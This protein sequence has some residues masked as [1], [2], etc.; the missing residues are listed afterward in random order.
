M[1]STKFFLLSVVLLLMVSVSTLQAQTSIF[2]DFVCDSPDCEGVAPLEG[3]WELSDTGL[4]PNERRGGNPGEIINFYLEIGPQSFNLSDFSEPFSGKIILICNDGSSLEGLY[5]GNPSNTIE[6]SKVENFVKT[7]TVTMH[8]QLT[9][10]TRSISC[11][12]AGCGDIN[13][14]V[15]PGRW[16]RRGAEPPDSDGDGVPDDQD[17]CQGGDDNV[18]TDGDLVP[19]F[20]D[21]CPNDIENDADGDGVC[22]DVDSCPGGNDNENADGDALPDF[23]DVCPIDPDNDADGDG[24]CGD[25]DNCPIIANDNQNDIDG[26]NIGDVCDNDIDGDTVLNDNDNCPYDVNTGQTDTDNDGAGDVCDDDIDGDGVLD[27]DDACVPTP[28]G[29][30]VNADGCSISELCPCAYPDGADR[31]KNHGAYVRCV[32]HTSEDFVSAGLITEIEKDA[33]VSEAGGSSCGHK[34]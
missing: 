27:A 19:D 15:V 22:G 21:P 7:A 16:V 2:F 34:K 14:I 26:D 9:E 12:R 8:N 28:L 1:K 3:F 29:E 20:C 5:Q 18:D 13:G 6:F 24:V 4:V 10:A 31:W 32:A 25:V 33:I 30:V 11:I 17:I 23:C